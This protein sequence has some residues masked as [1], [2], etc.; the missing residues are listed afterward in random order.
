MAAPN[1][2]NVA[3]IYGK[4]ATGVASATATALVSNAGGSGKVLK[5]NSLYCA[6]VDGSATYTVTIDIY[7]SSTAYRIAAAVPVPISATLDILS[8]SIYLEEGDSLR[9][10]GNVA[11]KIEVICSYEEIS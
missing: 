11:N 7:R 3:N 1:I 9:I 6:N 8:S 4:I 2:V 5:L 10:T